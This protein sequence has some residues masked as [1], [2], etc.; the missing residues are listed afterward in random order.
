LRLVPTAY[1][2]RSE[3]LDLPEIILL[4]ESDLIESCR[5]S[6]VFVPVLSIPVQVVDLLQEAA[7]D[8]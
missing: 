4:L 7:H 2:E 8:E 5:L 3:P 1:E 6:L